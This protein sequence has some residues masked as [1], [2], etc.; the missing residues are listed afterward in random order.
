MAASGWISDTTCDAAARRI[1]P[2]RA[3]ARMPRRAARSPSTA[4]REE[5]SRVGRTPIVGPGP[6]Q[7]DPI[8]SA[9]KRKTGRNSD[10]FAIRQSM[11][12]LNA[13]Y[14]KQNRLQARTRL[15]RNVKGQQVDL[16]VRITP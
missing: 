1:K 8:R 2:R 10:Y 13:L 12:K 16:T 15:E 9:P 4:A 5:A 14:E 7:E 11:R 3:S 6:V